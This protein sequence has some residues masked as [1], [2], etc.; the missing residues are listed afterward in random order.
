MWRKFPP[1]NYNSKEWAICIENMLANFLS[2]LIALDFGW[3]ASFSLGNIF[4]LFTI[5]SAQYFLSGGKNV[6]INFCLTA[7]L[8]MGTLDFIAISGLVVYT[9]TAICFLYL[10]RV[11]VLLF[12]EKTKEGAKLIPLCWVVSFYVVVLLH[13]LHII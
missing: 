7:A 2:H 8:L 13:N 12:L 6:L 3:M 4:W 1:I 10:S 5:L 9:A 11:V